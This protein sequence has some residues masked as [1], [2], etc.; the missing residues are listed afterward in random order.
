MPVIGYS[1]SSSN[2][3]FNSS[4]IMQEMASDNIPTPFVAMS[5]TDETVD[6]NNLIIESTTSV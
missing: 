6:S 1:I 4:V 2:S 5:E 3:P